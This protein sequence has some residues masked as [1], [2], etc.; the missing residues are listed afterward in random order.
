MKEIGPLLPF[1]INKLHLNQ[2]HQVTK[3][4]INNYFQIKNNYFQS[5]IE[6]ENIFALE[7]QKCHSP[8]FMNAEE[9]KKAKSLNE[10]HEF[11]S[12]MDLDADEKLQLSRNSPASLTATKNYS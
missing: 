9:Q 4:K 8:C 12:Q 6:L 11:G 10:I 3:K 1:L 7:I 2:N 5:P